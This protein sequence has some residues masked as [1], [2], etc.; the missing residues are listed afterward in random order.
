[1]TCCAVTSHGG[2]LPRPA[3]TVPATPTVTGD[4]AAALGEPGRGRDGPALAG[5]P[6]RGPRHESRVTVTARA[7]DARRV[8]ANS[9][10]TLTLSLSLAALTEPQGLTLVTS[11]DS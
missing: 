10:Q 9:W 6:G 2:G 7:S 4:V 1:M 11:H 5:R 8:S 3:V